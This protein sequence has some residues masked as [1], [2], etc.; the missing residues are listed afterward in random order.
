M[1]EKIKLESLL[2]TCYELEGLLMLAIKRDAETPE[3]VYESI[4]AKI[5]SLAD[6][7]SS[8]QP[9]PCQTDM[10]TED[11][12]E[13]SKAVEY[14]EESDANLDQTKIAAIKSATASHT[15]FAINDRYQFIRELFNGNE[16]EFKDAVD[17]LEEMETPEEMA[18]YLYNDLC[19]NEQDPIVCHFISIMMSSK[20]HE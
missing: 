13:M 6:N 5:R 4:E 8:L 11:A 7:Y 10:S 16:A 1:M 14:E 18:D 17:A 20:N 12:D 15:K 2:S 9:S 3:P 19:L